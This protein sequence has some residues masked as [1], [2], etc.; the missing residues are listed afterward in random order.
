MTSRLVTVRCPQGLH[1]R[2]ASSIA[3]IAQ[4]SAATVNIGC[5]GCPQSNACSVLQLLM[6]GATAGTTLEIA[7]EGP[8]EEAVLAAL[9][10]VFEQGGGI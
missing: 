9:A 1:L 3:K 7:A 2:L 4:A 8:G 6:L 5:E 10:E